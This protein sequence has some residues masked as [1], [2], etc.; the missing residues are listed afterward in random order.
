MVQPRPAHTMSN[1]SSLVAEVFCRRNR[2]IR[3]WSALRAAGSDRMMLLVTERC[4]LWRSCAV[5]KGMPTED[6][7]LSVKELLMAGS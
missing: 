5:V 3:D 1:D 2:K 6:A 7:R 4:K